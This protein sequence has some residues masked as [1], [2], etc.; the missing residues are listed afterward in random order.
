[1]WRGSEACFPPGFCSSLSS[2]PSPPTLSV[3]R[4]CMIVMGF[5]SSFNR[6]SRTRLALASRT[7]SVGLNRYFAR[8]QKKKKKRWPIGTASASAGRTRGP[9]AR[10]RMGMRMSVP[11]CDQQCPIRRR[12]RLGR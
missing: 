5:S 7:L 9:P 1:M 10:A 12:R 8:M 2:F 4:M 3:I 6:M 11:M